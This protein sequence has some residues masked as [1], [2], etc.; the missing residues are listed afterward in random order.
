MGRVKTKEIKRMSFSLMEKNPSLFTSEFAKNKKAITEMK[1]FD[2]KR[3]IN[4]IAGYITKTTKRKQ[5]PKP[6]EAEVMEKET[7]DQQ[8]E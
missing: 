1:V 7:K 3:A 2:E 5:G 8:E 4:K 6:A